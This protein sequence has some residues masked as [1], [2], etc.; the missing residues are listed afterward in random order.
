MVQTKTIGMAKAQK[1]APMSLVTAKQAEGGAPVATG[2]FQARPPGPAA[3][4][5][6]PFGRGGPAP[7][8]RGGFTGRGG[9]GAG[10][11]VAHVDNRPTRFLVKNIPSDLQGEDPLR[12]HFKV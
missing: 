8:G 12:T 5:P 11:P 9:H 6:R 3:V 7:R 2:G 10:A 4:R 1:G